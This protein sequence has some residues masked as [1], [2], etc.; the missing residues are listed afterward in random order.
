[1]RIALLFI[2]ALS[3]DAQTVITH[4]GP[5]F[6]QI[7]NGTSMARFWVGALA[8][9]PYAVEIAVFGPQGALQSIAVGMPVS[10]TV[11]STAIG[12]SA[13]TWLFKPNTQDPTKIDYQITGLGPGDA[14]EVK[15]IGTI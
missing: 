15:E 8:P 9:K 6:I 13:F 12:P 5:N 14:T 3:L 2:A 4:S 11:G 1:M 7:T 10:A